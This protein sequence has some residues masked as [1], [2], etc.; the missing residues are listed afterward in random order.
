MSG[1]YEDEY[2]TLRSF[3]SEGFYHTG[4]L[5]V[6]DPC[7]NFKITGRLKNTI[8]RGGETFSAEDVEASLREMPGIVDVAVCGIPDQA[9]GEKTCAFIVCSGDAPN[10]ESIREFLNNIGIAPFKHPDRVEIRE[11][12]PLTP[13]G[14]IDFNA[15]KTSIR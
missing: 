1:Y 7:G 9:L 13:I 5:A 8:N 15:L 6:R 12:L 2:S 10:L 4:D 14:K 11:L 3:D